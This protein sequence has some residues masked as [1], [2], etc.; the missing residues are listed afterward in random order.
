MRTE[1]GFWMKGA[2]TLDK[3]NTATRR[4]VQLAKGVFLN[5]YWDEENAPRP[6]GYAID[7]KIAKDSPDENIYRNIRAA[8]ESGWD[9]SGRWVSDC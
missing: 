7:K 1:Y 2:Y 5:R 6:E 8:C 4:V 3:C 9:F